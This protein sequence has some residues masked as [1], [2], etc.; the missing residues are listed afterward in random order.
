MRVRD[1]WGRHDLLHRDDN[2]FQD[3]CW[4]SG[5]PRLLNDSV[6][7]VEFVSGVPDGTSG[8]IWFNQ[9]VVA[10]NFVAV[11]FLSLF[12]DVSCVIILH[13]ILEL[14]LG[15]SLKMSNESYG[16]LKE[17]ITVGVKCVQH[18]VSKARRR[19]VN[20]KARE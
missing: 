5:M 10:F 4:V 9:A 17:V 13:S 12:L 1:C 2:F 11:P 8:A 19:K 18:F 6:E 16:K 7:P 14:I 20:W 15:R 3:G